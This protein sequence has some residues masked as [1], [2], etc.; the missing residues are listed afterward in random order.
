MLYVEIN[1][2]PERELPQ[3]LRQFPDAPDKPGLAVGIRH[4]LDA[5][6]W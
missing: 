3:T 4:C 1:S 5:V 6:P 2:R